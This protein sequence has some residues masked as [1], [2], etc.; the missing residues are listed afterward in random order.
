MLLIMMIRSQKP[1][2]VQAGFIKLSMNSLTAVNNIQ[3]SFLF[4]NVTEKKK[5]F[6]Y[7]QIRLNIDKVWK[8][9]N[10][11]IFVIILE[12]NEIRQFFI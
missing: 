8:P 12:I 6:K 10:K 11:L 1:L 4:L 5:I 2:T 7:N 3:I 9:Y